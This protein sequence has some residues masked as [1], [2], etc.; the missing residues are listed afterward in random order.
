MGD[1]ERAKENFV[2]FIRAVFPR[3]DY[4]ARYP[5]AVVTQNAD[6]TLELKPDDD[7]FPPLS[8]VAIRL[9]LPGATVKVANGARVLL[10]FASGDPQQPIAELWESGS[11]TELD[12]NGT[13]IKL[14]G[15]TATVARTGDSITIN[16][17]QLTAAGATAGGQPVLVITPIQ[18][19]I[20]AGASGV[21]A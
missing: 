15:G 8:K 2:A 11:V 1:F 21:K 17:A 7:R 10:A 13:L 5:A 6:L 4:L 20:G 16:Q 12:L 14:N 19:T 18:G 9:G 3:I